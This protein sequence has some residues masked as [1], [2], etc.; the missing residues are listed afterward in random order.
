MSVFS[1]PSSSAA[2]DAAAYTK[3]VLG[4]LGERDPFPILQDMHGALIRGIH[5]L[6]TEDLRRPERPGKWSIA[7]VLQHLA[8]SEV[9]WAWRVRLILG[10]DRPMLTSYDQDLWAQ[11]L[12][13]DHASP[14]EAL[15]LFGVVRHANVRLVSR[16]R[17]EELDRVGIHAERGEESVRHLVRFHA[18]HDLLHLNQIA[19]VRA[20]V[21]AGS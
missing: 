4:L 19:R 12:H 8:D 3:A 16:A 14:A 21:E 5:G 17:P 6:S 10:Q 11:R 15:E 2:A 7:T 13:Y 9:V 20:A 1:N 18:G